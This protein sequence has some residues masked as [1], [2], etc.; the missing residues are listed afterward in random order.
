MRSVHLHDPYMVRFYKAKKNN[1]QHIEQRKKEKSK[2][3]KKTKV[4]K[5]RFQISVCRIIFQKKKKE[6][7]NEISQNLVCLKI[8]T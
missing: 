8:R 6:E 7:K 1:K 2:L 5:S 3:K 4:N